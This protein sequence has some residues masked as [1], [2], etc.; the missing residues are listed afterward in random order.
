MHEPFLTS[1]VFLPLPLGEGRGEG[2]FVALAA[3]EGT[4]TR[5]A[6]GL[7][8]RER[9]F[10][11]LS[12]TTAT[13]MPNRIAT[14]GFFHG[15]LTDPRQLLADWQRDDAAAADRCSQHHAA[16]MVKVAK[17]HNAD[18]YK[19]T[20]FCDLGNLDAV[21]EPRRACSF[22]GIPERQPQTPK[23]MG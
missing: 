19:R 11:Y 5:P 7:S 2:A 17:Q 3:V 9:Q 14:E 13:D 23:N 4:L 8:Q 16:G 12:I 18:I 15:R 20:L 10:R 21:P 6:A 22:P 1:S